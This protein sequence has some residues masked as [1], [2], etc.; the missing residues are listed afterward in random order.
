MVYA[1][2]RVLFFV[3]SNE[4]ALLVLSDLLYPGWSAFVDGSYVTLY[5]V[6]GLFRGVLVPPGSHHIEMRFTP[7]SLRL[8]IGMLGIA[9]LLIICIWVQT[10]HKLQGANE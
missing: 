2:N 3:E 9:L 6:N 10:K 7:Q 8:G 5:E 4:R 1:P